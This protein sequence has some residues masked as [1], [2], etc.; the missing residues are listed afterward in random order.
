MKNLLLI[1]FLL[2]VFK[3][4]DAQTNLYHPFPDSNAVWNGRDLQ[5]YDCHGGL[6]FYNESYT[7]ILSGDTI[8]NSVS[9]HKLITPVAISSDAT[10]PLYHPMGYTGGIRQDIFNKKVFLVVPGDS[11][12]QLLY[13][14]DLQI[15]DTLRGYL[16]SSCLNFPDAFRV[17]GEDSILIGSNY[18]KRWYMNSFNG[19]FDYIIEGIGATEGLLNVFCSHIE[20]IYDLTCFS[21]DGQTLYP[22]TSTSCGL[23]DATNDFYREIISATFFPNPF[24]TKATLKF[25]TQNRIEFAYLKIYNSIGLLVRVQCLDIGKSGAI[26]FTR[27]ELS[28]GLY[29]YELLTNNYEPVGNGKFVIE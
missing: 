2:I 20:S 25:S 6:T 17:T 7:H 28:V 5:Q 22:D 16:V 4:S 3:S 9:F 26:N 13:D 23:I 11:I 10:C 29:F 15:G 19:A 1:Y 18:R 24:H 21:Q 27:D 14:F 12:E 8:I